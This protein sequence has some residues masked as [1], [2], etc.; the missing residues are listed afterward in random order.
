MLSSK[1][2]KNIEKEYRY[3]IHISDIHIRLNYRHEEY[4]DVFQNLYNDIDEKKLNYDET[5]I[6][7]TGDLLHDKT[8]LTS[9]AIILCTDFLNNLSKRYKTILIA[10]NHD[11]FLN[12]DEKIDMI[13]GVIHGKEMNDLY[14]YKN[15]NIVRFKNILFGICSVFDESIIPSPYLDQYILDNDLNLN[16]IK[17]GLYHGM[18]GTVKLQNLY[19]SKGGLS[20]EDFKGYDY[21]LLGDIHRFQYLNDEKT[22]AYASSLVSQNFSEHDKYHGYILWD[23]QE[24]TSSFYPIKNDYQYKKAF[25]NNDT[26]SIDEISFNIMTDIEEMRDYLPKKGRIQVILEDNNFEKM[27]YIKNKLKDIYWVEVNNILNKYD[28]NKKKTKLNTTNNF[29]INRRDII[30]EILKNKYEKNID[31]NIIDWIDNEIQNNDI[32]T[33]RDGDK[34]EVLKLKFSNLFVY[35]ENNEIDLGKFNEKDIILICGKNSSGKSSIIDIIVFNLYN[36]Y[37][38]EVSSQIKK[39]NSGILN[40]EKCEGYSELLIRIANEYYI[41]RREYKKNKKGLVETDSYLYKSFVSN[42]DETELITTKK[43]KNNKIEKYVYNNEEYKLK[44]IMEGASVNKEIIKMVGT[45]DNFLLMNMMMQ[46]DN[47]SFKNMSQTE[48]KKMLIKLL[49]LEKY[50]KMK[51]A[52]EDS[53]KKVNKDYDIMKNDMDKIDIDGIRE[54]IKMNEEKINELTIRLNEKNKENDTIQNKITKLNIEHIPIQYDILN[55]EVNIINNIKKIKED[56]ILLEQKIKYNEHKEYEIK[57][58]IHDFENNNKY[59]NQCIDQYNKELLEDIS[60]NIDKL[61]N[62]LETNIRGINKLYETKYKN[63]EELDNEYNNLKKD[64]NEN[65]IEEYNNKKEEHEVFL[66]KFQNK[67]RELTNKILIHTEKIKSIISCDAC[68]EYEKI[69]EE[70]YKSNG[71]ALNKL[72]KELTENEYNIDKNEK[73]MKIKRDKLNMLIDGKSDEKDKIIVERYEKM[74]KMKEMI[75]N[76]DNQIEMYKKIIEEFNSHE[77]NKDCEKCMKNPKVVELKRIE[78]IINDLNEKTYKI[79]KELNE[80]NNIEKDMEDLTKINNEIKLLN[81]N[82]D[83]LLNNNNNIKNKINKNKE[84]IIKKEYEQKYYDIKKIINELENDKVLIA[85]K[86]M[87]EDNIKELNNMETIIEKDKIK[88]EKFGMMEKEKILIIKNENIKMENDKIEEEIIKIKAEINENKNKKVKIE[89]EM[90]DY[91]NNKIEYNEIKNEII[92]VKNKYEMNS[93]YMGNYEKDME[94][95]QME[96]EYIEKNKKNE[97]EIDMLKMVNK[98]RIDEINKI[99]EDIIK[100]SEENKVKNKVK[101][102]YEMNKNKFVLIQYEK[103]K[104]EYYKD[105]LDKDGLSLYIIKTYLEFITNGINEIIGGQIDKRVRIYEEDEKINIEIRDINGELVEFMGGMETFITE[106]AFKI[107]LS[108]IMEMNRGNLIIIDEGISAL[109]KEQLGKIDDLLNFI[110]THYEYILLMSHIEEIKDKVN[111]KIYIKKENGMSKIV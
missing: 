50:D 81:N 101:D 103:E 99:K 100:M 71:T 16:T 17:I 93:V 102:E 39:S 31:E 56:N 25:L 10:G 2:I 20:V 37:A 53:R 42:T 32:K 1:I 106:I 79:N 82:I 61:N 105:I 92:N 44:L 55:N 109:D 47:I 65:I 62:N 63:I 9:E 67:E 4:R 77:Y 33:T 36:D 35:G 80:Y 45:K 69:N 29:Y 78:F 43:P 85:F 83:I 111:N 76:N 41:I 60:N 13:T 40:N 51:L 98:K 64:I 8:T 12:T 87:I 68:N 72:D 108:K 49:E 5:L 24:H 110:N 97:D 96:K 52:M 95:I 7:V 18:I 3:I 46:N 66:K 30:K 84:D 28:E 74:C 14:Y 104:Y 94:K 23:L 58:K 15:N 89:Y 22:I 88:M 6:V 91:M 34:F 75:K 27:R 21:V 107:V 59:A 70:K 19:D 86:Q 57:G 73:E 11:G 26:F 48:R 54:V 38:R 90:K